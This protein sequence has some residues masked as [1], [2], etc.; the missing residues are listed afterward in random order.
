MNTCVLCGGTAVFWQADRRRPYLRCQRC[1]LVQVPA[2]HQLDADA[3]LAE[4]RLHRNDPDDPGYR[5]FLSRLA[6]PLLQHLPADSSGLDFGCGPAPALAMLLREQGHRV[7]LHDLYFANNPQVFDQQWDFIC[8]SEVVEHLAQPGEE[9]HRLWQCL[10]AGGWLALMTKR[11]R[12]AEAFANWHYKNDPT[13][14]CFFSVP[15]FD[16]LAAH[17]QTRAEYP[18]DDVVLLR[19]PL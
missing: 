7:A 11:V 18:A 17:W 15:T 10:K 4:Y 5:R 12:D 6:E 9:L 3:E 13:H 16:W 1:L 19:K 2:D 8:A 14:I